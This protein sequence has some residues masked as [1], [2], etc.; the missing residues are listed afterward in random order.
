MARSDSV[1]LARNCRLTR[2]PFHPP[3][4]PGTATRTA[5]A[6]SDQP[7]DAEPIVVTTAANTPVVM[8]LS[9]AIRRLPVAPPIPPHI[10]PAGTP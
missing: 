3:I 10:A 8:P 9:I 4:T 5:K 1:L 6:I 7:P 2:A